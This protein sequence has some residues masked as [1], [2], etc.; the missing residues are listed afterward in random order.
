MVFLL[1]QFTDA[2]ILLLALIYLELL[3]ISFRIPKI[4]TLA[5]E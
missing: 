1:D 2:A 3:S 4:I 5:G